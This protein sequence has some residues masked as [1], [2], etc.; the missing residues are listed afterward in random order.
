M[1]LTIN[2]INNTNMLSDKIK[3]KSLIKAT[4]SSRDVIKE[5]KAKAKN[6]RKTNQ[7]NKVGEGKTKTHLQKGH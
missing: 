2:I 4:I 6:Y 3:L 5:K 7:T 1:M